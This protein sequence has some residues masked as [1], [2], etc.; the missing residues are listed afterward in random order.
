M[1]FAVHSFGNMQIAYRVANAKATPDVAASTAP[2]AAP[3]TPQGQATKTAPPARAVEAQVFGYSAALSQQLEITKQIQPGVQ[4]GAIGR[5]AP[6]DGAAARGPAPTRP[7]LNGPPSEMG[8]AHQSRAGKNP[9][10]AAHMA[11]DS[12]KASNA[13]NASNAG[14]VTS[15]ETSGTTSSARAAQVSALYE[16]AQRF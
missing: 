16:A 2:S 12:L 1:S 11:L 8:A 3:Q 15:R 6:E 14:E 10:E 5:Q 7:P 4:P 9:L 13:S